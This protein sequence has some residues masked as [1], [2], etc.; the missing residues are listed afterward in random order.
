MRIRGLVALLGVVTLVLSCGGGDGD[1]TDPNGPGGGGGQV[2]GDIAY[3]ASVAEIE[4]TLTEVKQLSVQVDLTNQ[5]GEQL[6]RAY[7]AGCPVRVRLYRPLD[8]ALVYDESRTPCTAENP[9]DFTIGP[10]GTVQPAS[11]P[12]NP[13]FVHGDTIAAPATYNAAALVR[14]VGQNPIEIDSGTYRLPFCK[15]SIPAGGLPFTHCAY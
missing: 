3:V 9:V 15:D 12:R 1:I 10:H 6:A 2:F 4:H 11:G 13:W 5:T 14:I 8:G 7:P